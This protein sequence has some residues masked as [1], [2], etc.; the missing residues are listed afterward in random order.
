MNIPDMAKVLNHLRR[1][2]VV[3]VAAQRIF[4]TTPQSSVSNM[5]ICAWVMPFCCHETA[6]HDFM[7]SHLLLYAASCAN[8]FQ[9]LHVLAREHVVSTY[10]LH[11]LL[12]CR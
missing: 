1:D 3:K 4:M 2:P 9:C 8:I 7:T 11:G 10:M 6:V 5:S 12:Q